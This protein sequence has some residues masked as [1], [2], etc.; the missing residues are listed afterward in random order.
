MKVRDCMAH[1]LEGV[2]GGDSARTAAERMA[3]LGVGSLPVFEA[4]RA[5][6]MVTDRDLVVRVLARGLDG[7]T[8]VRQAM[9]RGIVICFADDDVR[10]AA[11]TM[12]RERVRRLIVVDRELQAIGMLS[13]DDLAL[14]GCDPELVADV[15]RGS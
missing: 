10:Q 7:A 5:V 8:P 11:A 3:A 1:R 13:V 2:D 4:G 12:A 9:T 15:T 6:G 14:H